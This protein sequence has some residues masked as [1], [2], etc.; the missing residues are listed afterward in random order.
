MSVVRT[1]PP[2]VE[3]SR[4]Y[5]DPKTG[6]RRLHLL[7]ILWAN[8]S[9][10]GPW[11]EPKVSVLSDFESSLELLM[12][13]KT[14][15]P[16]AKSIRDNI[17]EIRGEDREVRLFWFKAYISTAGNERADELDKLAA[18]RSD[19]SSD[20][21]K[22]PLFYVKKRVQGKSVLKW[23]DR[24]QSSSTGEVQVLTGHG[25]IALYLHRFRLKDNPGCECGAEVE[26]TVW[27]ILLECSRFL[28]AR[29]Q[30]EHKIEQDLT[31]EAVPHIMANPTKRLLFLEYAEVIFRIATKR[32]SGL[33]TRTLTHI[34]PQSNIQ[35]VNQP[36]TQVL[37]EGHTELIQAITTT[38]SIKEEILKCREKGSPGF[39]VRSVALFM[40]CNTERLGISFRCTTGPRSMSISP[41]LAVLLNG[42]IFK[43]SM[44]CKVFNA[45]SL[46][47]VGGKN[48]NSQTILRGKMSIIHMAAYSATNSFV[49]LDK[50]QTDRTLKP[51]YITP[52]YDLCY[53][54][55]YVYFVPPEARNRGSGWGRCP[56]DLGT[57]PRKVDELCI[58]EIEE[59]AL[60]DGEGHA[61]SCDAV[62]ASAGFNPSGLIGLNWGHEAPPPSTPRHVSRIKNKQWANEKCMREAVRGDS[63][64][65]LA[66]AQR[67]PTAAASVWAYPTFPLKY[68]CCARGRPIIVEWER[69]ARHSAGLPLVR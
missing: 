4:F 22:V 25:G 45:L 28:T 54:C 60:G 24:Y 62:S 41:G 42:S 38:I 58:A 44:K 1:P 10:I 3:G 15:H 47:E 37:L 52:S 18:L 68:K 56:T 31:Q 17:L 67:W 9:F 69:D 63:R 48:C 39:R 21:D 11:T 65:R 46:A 33:Q 19:T 59:A 36:W 26:E 30:L 49:A 64:H 32:N 27:H 34:N 13:S 2:P 12:D 53:V 6:K 50:E 29:L 7:T 5:S 16:L 61:R 66:R 51:E 35:N 57:R 55:I 23:Q 40:D 8:R 20:Y 14:E 43:T